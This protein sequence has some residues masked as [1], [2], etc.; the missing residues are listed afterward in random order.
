MSSH[1][2]D[3]IRQFIIEN[4]DPSTLSSDPLVGLQMKEDLLLKYTTCLL[5]DSLDDYDGNESEIDET[6]GDDFTNVVLK[7]LDFSE[8]PIDPPVSHP[9]EIVTK[10]YVDD[11][12]EGAVDWV[13]PPITAT[14]S[15][16]QGQTSYDENYF[17]VCVLDN[18]WR[19][20]AIAA[21]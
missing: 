9:G 5:R 7:R 1:I 6:L 4:V 17:Y 19:R 21:W 2:L 15:G 13:P 18:V 16:T 8:I 14:S 3:G 12:I 10:K 11:Q 20:T